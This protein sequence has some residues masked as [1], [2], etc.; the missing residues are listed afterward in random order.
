MAG[1]CYL[2]ECK[3]EAAV[4]VMLQFPCGEATVRAVLDL[5][6]CSQHGGVFTP[7]SLLQGGYGAFLKRHFEQLNLPQPLL[8]ALSCKTVPLNG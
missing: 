6:L 7:R 3:R 8:E 1:L 4:A 2:S 5:R